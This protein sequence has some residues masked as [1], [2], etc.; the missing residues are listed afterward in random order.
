M[1]T[2]RWFSGSRITARATVSSNSACTHMGG[3]STGWE[4][5][6]GKLAGS[7]Y[8]FDK[9]TRVHYGYTWNAEPVGACPGTA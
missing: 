4:R 2:A 6:A 5:Q 3:H 1:S 9:S 7:V 8:M